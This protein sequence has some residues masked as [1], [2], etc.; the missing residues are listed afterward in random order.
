MPRT[1][2][3]VTLFSESYFQIFQT[4]LRFVDQNSKTKSE[5]RL[6]AEE[7]LIHVLAKT[8]QN[9]E[10][11][12]KRKTFIGPFGLNGHSWVLVFE[13]FPRVEVSSGSR[14]CSPC[15]HCSPSPADF[16]AKEAQSMPWHGSLPQDF[17]IKITQIVKIIWCLSLFLFSEAYDTALQ[18]IHFLVWFGTWLLWSLMSQTHWA[19][20]IMQRCESCAFLWPH[21]KP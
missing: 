15:I 2:Q 21:N 10:P 5:V 16:S 11:V 13:I 1:W 19:M 14:P 6:I 4:W 9:P 12:V 17:Q 20:A 18:G 8:P 3:K 7:R